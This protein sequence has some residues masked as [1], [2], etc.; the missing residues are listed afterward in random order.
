M[1]LLL[2][3]LLI[4][5]LRM[6]SR[7][8]WSGHESLFAESVSWHCTKRGGMSCLTV[9]YRIHLRYRVL[10]DLACLRPEYSIKR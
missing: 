4:D 1:L 8:G 7:P 2:R 3:R 6:E 9:R 5:Y 10:A